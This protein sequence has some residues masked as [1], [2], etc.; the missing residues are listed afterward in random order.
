[1]KRAFSKTTAIQ[2]LSKK[3]TALTGVYAGVRRLYSRN[4]ES[5]YV[6]IRIPLGNMSD[7]AVY[8]KYN[9]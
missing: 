3:F 2:N 1:M 7:T 4:S 8:I 5:R 6:D 9:L